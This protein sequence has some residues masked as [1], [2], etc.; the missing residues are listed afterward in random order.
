MTRLDAL[1]PVPLAAEPFIEEACRVTGLSD[2]GPEG[3]RE[4][5]EV[6]LSSIN[7]EAHLSEAGL[8]MFHGW[9]LRRLTNR[10]RVVDWV[11]RHP[12]VKRERVEKPLFVCGMPRTGTTVL[13][14]MLSQ[15]P[16]NRPLMKWESMNAVPPP[17]AATFETDPRIAQAVAE[18]EEVFARAPEM[19]AVH[20]EPPDGPTECVELLT[21]HFVGHDWSFWVV[22]SYFAWFDYCDMR[23]ALQYHK[24][25]LQLLQSRAPGR[26]VLKATSHTLYL[27]AIFATYADARVVIPHRDP[28]KSV[29]SMAALSC[30]CRPEL[31]TSAYDAD[32]CREFYGPFWMNE[33]RIMVDKMMAFREQHPDA[34]IYDLRY[35]DFIRD[36]LGSVRDLYAYFDEEL[37]EEVASRM[38]R[39]LEENPKGH[40]GGHHYTPEAFNLST[41]RLAECFA[42]YV[43]RYG[44]TEAG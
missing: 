38:E 33:F 5:F 43:E 21:Q 12:E 20:Y 27:D 34:N 1:S 19:K 18:V 36:P 2:F 41:P 10:L 11:E 28:G 26:W 4:A 29:A 13:Y 14:S 40:F 39:Y 30:S 31:L 17:E 32:D 24:L 25:C 44:L 15:D 42:Q 35:A 8:E 16:R 3:W 7:S 37:T 22:P 6:L 9:V 23:S